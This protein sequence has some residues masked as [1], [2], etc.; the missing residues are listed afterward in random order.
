[1]KIWWGE[2]YIGVK[3]ARAPTTQPNPIA[4]ELDEKLLRRSGSAKLILIE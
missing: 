3:S 1:M 2:G 4:I